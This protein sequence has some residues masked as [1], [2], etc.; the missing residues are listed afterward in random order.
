[1]KVLLV[2][3]QT[4]MNNSGEAVRDIASFYKIPPQNIIVIVDDINFDT[5]VLRIR[6]KGSDGGQKGIRDIIELL[7]TEEIMRI[8]IG[9]G[10]KPRPDYDVVSWVL[11]K[12]PEE[13]KNDLNKALENAVKAC[14]EIILRGIDSAMNKYNN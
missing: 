12:F 3:P 5:G 4:Y 2:K 14:D 13:Q 9:V 10:K 11:G 1:M 6:P 7:G 8:K